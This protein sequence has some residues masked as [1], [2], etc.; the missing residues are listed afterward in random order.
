MAEEELLNS[1]SLAQAAVWADIKPRQ[2]A[3]LLAQGV[4]P[5][6]PV[7]GPHVQKLAGGVRRKRRCWRWIIPR[8]SFQNAWRTFAPQ[9]QRRRA[10]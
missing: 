8:E 4:L 10:R 5:G 6:L 1:W 9:P 3:D 7:G 2:L